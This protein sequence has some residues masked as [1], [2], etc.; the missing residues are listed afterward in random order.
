MSK[1]PL[2]SIVDDDALARDGIRELV[3]SLRYRVTTFGSA[4]DFLQ[5]SMVA[6]TACLI[7]DLQMPGL[8]GLELQEALQSLGHQTPV[9]VITAYPNEKHRTRALENGAVGYL[10]KPFDEQTLIECLTVAINLQSSQRGGGTAARNECP[11]HVA[12]GVLGNKCHICGFFNGLDEQHRVLR[13][14]IKEGFERGEKALHIMDPSLREDHLKRLTDA[15]IDVGQAIATGQ[16]EVLRWQD[17]YLRDDR[18]DKDRMAA[19]FE[20]LLQSKAVADHPRMRLVSRVEPSL[21]DKAGIEGWLEYETRINY[22]L[23]KYDDPVI[24]A[25][26]LSNFSANVVMDLLRVHPVV[27]VGGVLQENP[28]FVRPEQF[29]LELQER[30]SAENGSIQAH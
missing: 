30:K 29:L 14:F 27:I 3:E 21:L 20:N 1:A 10:S 24:C 8:S 16:L 13:S 6:E 23:S 18:F 15:G 7:T 28:F 26:D 2:I 9:I 4:E 22:V 17:A 25:Y 19:F 11:I 12:D 5:S